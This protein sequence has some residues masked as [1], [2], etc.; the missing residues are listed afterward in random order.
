MVKVDVSFRVTGSEIPAD[1]GYHLLSAIARVVP[2][3]HGDD[4]VGVHPIG[5]RLIGNRRLALTDRSRVTIRLDSERIGQIL[6][7]AGQPLEIDGCRIR[8]GVPQTRALVPAAR[9]YSRLV[10][11][12]GFLEPEPFLEAVRRQL[13]SL[14]IRGEPSLVAQPEIA[15]ANRNRAT[16]TR[17]L[18]LRR[19]IRIRDKE[20]VGFAVR[21]QHL[22]AEESVRLQ[23]HGL[24]GRRRFGCGIFI[25]DRR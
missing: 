6:P 20:V 8:V 4:E 21:V 3:L 7:L 5:G 25:P 2:K 10:V 12:K 24:G 13:E 17:S 18:Y 22:T 14:E 16:G 11:I 1:H 9:L 19:T 23:E 15:A